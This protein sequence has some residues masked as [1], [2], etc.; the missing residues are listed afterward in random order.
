M[1]G[2]LGKASLH[3]RPGACRRKQGEESTSRG[4]FSIPL[5]RIRGPAGVP[6]SHRGNEAATSPEQRARR[7]GAEARRAV[8]RA[9]GGV[10]SPALSHVRLFPYWGDHVNRVS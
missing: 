1:L 6:F 8:A 7:E 3:Q 5:A 2:S 4:W 10:P 9:R